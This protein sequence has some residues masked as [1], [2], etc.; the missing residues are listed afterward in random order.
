M[1]AVE[2]KP[3]NLTLVEQVVERVPEWTWETVQKA[4]V[5]HLVDLMSTAVLER[6]TGAPDGCD[7]ADDILLQYYKA[8]GTRE[9]LITD[10]FN[11]L[12]EEYTLFLLDSLQLEK[13]PQPTNPC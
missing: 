8:V 13:I 12:G 9:E 7:I 11:I 6:L 5:T 10:A 4:I 1:I 3:V 2:N